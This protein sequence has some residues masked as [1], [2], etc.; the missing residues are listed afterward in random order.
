[1]RTPCPQRHFSVHS[2]SSCNVGYFPDSDQVEGKQLATEFKREQYQILGTPAK[3][4]L[5][6]ISGLLLLP[7]ELPVLFLLFRVAPLPGIPRN[8]AA[9][10]QIANSI[11]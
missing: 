11:H 3:N 7:L 1:M 10:S 2:T 5:S 8:Q 4:M 6:L 9:R